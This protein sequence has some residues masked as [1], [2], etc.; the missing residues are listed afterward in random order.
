MKNIPKKK[1]NKNANDTTTSGWN[2]PLT[3]TMKLNI[4]NRDAWLQHCE[5]YCLQNYGVA[6]KCITELKYREFK[7]DRTK[8]NGRSVEND[9]DKLI[10]KIEIQNA[11]EAVSRS[12]AQLDN[13]KLAVYAYL[14]RNMSEESL[15]LVQNN[16]DYSSVNNDPLKLVMLIR[17]THMGLENNNIERKVSAAS[18][19]FSLKQGKFT[20][21]HV[22]FQEW[23]SAYTD[24]ISTGNAEIDPVEQ[25]VLFLRSLNDDIYSSLK[26]D[27][28]NSSNLPGGKKFS[29]IDECFQY[30]LGHVSST[31]T[32]STSSNGSIFTTHKSLVKE[33]SN[34]KKN[35]KDKHHKEPPPEISSSSESNSINTTNTNI[36]TDKPSNN[37]RKP[38]VC[39]HCKKTGHTLYNCPT[40]EHNDS[41][42]VNHTDG[43][44]YH[45][46]GNVNDADCNGVI[47]VS[48][49][50][51]NRQWEPWEC[52]CDSGANVSV[53]KPELL[54]DICTS[55]NVLKVNGLNGHIFTLNK[56]GI[57]NNSLTVWVSIVHTVNIISL[58]Q[59][60]STGS[61]TYTP[62]KCF[63]YTSLNNNTITFYLKNGLYVANLQQYWN[64]TPVNNEINVA[65]VNDR[66]KEFSAK[67]VERA[68][69]V[70]QLIINAGYPGN[71]EMINIIN[72]NNINN[73]KFTLK[74]L[75]NAR[76]IYGT[77]S[78]AIKGKATNIKISTQ[79]P[80]H[81]IKSQTT[82]QHL[83]VD[84]MLVRQKPFLI[85]LSDPLNMIMSH[86]LQNQ[87]ADA[88][89][90]SL[91][92]MI[93][94][95]ASQGFQVT[96]IVCD[97]HASFKALVG[98]IPGV[99]IDVGGAGDCVPKV[100]IRIRRIE[101][102]MRSVNNSLPWKLP[103]LLIDTLV[104]Y[105][106]TRINSRSTSSRNDNVSPL[107][108]F[109][110][111]KP[112]YD[113]LFSIGFGDIC[114]V[115][116]HTVI[117]EHKSRTLAPRTITCVALYPVNNAQ[118]SWKFFNIATHQRITSSTWY[119]Q[120]TTELHS[121]SMNII[122]ENELLRIKKIPP[123]IPP[124]ESVEVD[125]Q[126]DLPIEVK[127]NVEPIRSDEIDTGVGDNGISINNSTEQIID[128][129]EFHE[130]NQSDAHTTYSFTKGINELGVDAKNA[131]T[132]EIRNMFV[133]KNAL[134][135]VKYDNL[136]N[137][138]KSNIIRSHMFIK[139][140]HHPDGTF[141]KVK[142]R[143]VA[144]GNMQE[145]CKFTDNYSPTVSVQSI[146]MVLKIAS[147]SQYIMSTFD[148][149]AAYLNA[150][151]DNEEVYMYIDKKLFAYIRSVYP[152][153][154]EFINNNNNLIVK[155]NKAVYGCKQSAKLWFN[156]LT[157]FLESIGFIKNSVD[158]CVFN[159][160]ENDNVTTILL[161]IDDLLVMSNNLTC[162][163]NL[164]D[165][166][167]I[168]FNEVSRNDGNKL[169][170]LGMT[171][172]KYDNGRIEISMKKFIDDLLTDSN[173]TNGKA[174]PAKCDLFISDDN[175]FLSDADAKWFHSTN[176]KLLYLSAR[177]RPDILMPV[178][179]LSTKVNHPS[180][181]D[182]NKLTRVLEYIYETRHD[183][184]SIS[185]EH[186]YGI[187]GFIDAS[188]GT[189]SDGKGHSGMCAFIGNSLIIAKSSKQKI[190]TVNSTESE[191]VALSDYADLILKLDEFMK[192]QRVNTYT[193]IIYQDNIS[194][195]HIV[196][197][198]NDKWRNIYIRGRRNKV[199]QYINDGHLV[200]DHISTGAMIA[201][202][203][204]KPLQGALFRKLKYQLLNN[205]NTML[206]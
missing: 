40:R 99:M 124:P 43:V 171:I 165:S 160:F 53:M 198:N 35:G 178:I 137:S 26:V 76:Y 46:D 119:L 197:N 122:A 89:G 163:D 128:S 64:D 135:P 44:N 157:G 61:V 194:T 111:R 154:D 193:P 192:V 200:I 134:T 30:V 19:L 141:D 55:T 179:Y 120:R 65:T 60:E 6:A 167:K 104:A 74:D 204:T 136:S 174:S 164:H 121:H 27:Y 123:E 18:K 82:N 176:A 126:H 155:L 49:A 148:I 140:K 156:T 94:L 191:L 189:H 203:L 183:V 146:M 66:E 195:I 23:R 37:N 100:D 42:S 85:G 15:S 80:D 170:Y 153:I 149:G 196:S 103:L 1:Y 139:V 20:K 113:K 14:I 51:G 173:I 152:N 159:K 112:D 7:L 62:G 115:P 45:L 96:R 133:T 32:S 34:K 8:F 31:I 161:Y 92:S 162:I 22:F 52:I 29:N 187:V 91:S 127:H 57:F 81:L 3:A 4:H 117:G 13:G 71:S 87:T 143:L 50:I 158:N 77:P 186:I 98:T 185:S 28:I 90:K 150:S 144:N 169:S 116:D 2:V 205:E 12:Q 206:I 168:R 118:Q 131:I 84:V 199:N 182:N 181:N 54:C 11:V 72:G 110:G 38:P 56:K 63:T 114:E 190:V 145:D 202:L 177:V 73:M 69:D 68:R 172:E 88:L 102:V 97:A 151:M 36:P 33:K 184:L 79:Q 17:K 109:T 41:K 75:A 201:D 175:N 142:A 5:L 101:E 24:F 138:Q 58:T 93:S 70:Q 188:F 86:A 25:A 10:L 105:A 107:V 9:V 48:E 16:I 59:L 130:V 166:L 83:Y 129:S 39:W 47:S 132:D 95:L 78:A 180:V 67:E 106:V 108:A 147:Q 21:I 125:I